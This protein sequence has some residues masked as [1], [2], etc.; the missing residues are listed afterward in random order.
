[1]ASRKYSTDGAREEQWNNEA[2]EKSSCYV[3]ASFK[4]IL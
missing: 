1:V 4:N 2:K 3:K